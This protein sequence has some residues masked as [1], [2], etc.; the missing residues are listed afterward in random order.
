MSFQSARHSLV[1]TDCFEIWY[2]HMDK[3]DCIC[4][5]DVS[6]DEFCCNSSIPF[7]YHSGEKGLHH[8]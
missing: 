5:I 6:H 4:D 8:C 2:E 3:C 7:K 1:L